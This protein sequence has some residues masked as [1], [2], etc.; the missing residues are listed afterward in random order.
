MDTHAIYEGAMRLLAAEV[1]GGQTLISLIS[2][3]TVAD[4]VA[5]AARTWIA[6]YKTVAAVVQERDLKGFQGEV[7][8]LDRP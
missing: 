6:A 3:E 8:S 2:E 7:V 5:L 4:A 1:V